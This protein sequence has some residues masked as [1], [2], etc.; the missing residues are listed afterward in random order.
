MKDLAGHFAWIALVLLS[1][2]CSETHEHPPTPSSS[3]PAPFIA[4]HGFHGIH[5]LTFDSEDQLYVGSVMGQS[6]YRVDRETGASQTVLFPPLGMADDLEFDSDGTLVWTSFI[7]GKVHARKKN[8]SE[9][10]ELASG[11]LGINSLAFKQDGRLFATQVFL[12]DAL[13]E[14]DLEGKAPPR[15]ILED[16]GG[17]NGFDFGPDGFLYGPLWF[18]GQVARVNVDTGELSV[19][20]DGFQI[21]AAVNFDSKGNLWVLDSARGEVIQLD[22]ETGERKRVFALKTCMDNLA[23]D[24]ADR[25]FVT[26]M[27]EN[28]IYELDTETGDVR[29]VKEGQLGVPADLAI[30]GESGGETLYVADTF[31]LRAINLETRQV[32]D[33]SRFV[34]DELE[35]P[36][37]IDVS[38]SFVYTASWFSGTIQKLDR[39]T[40]E[41]LD[42]LHGFTTPYDVLELED[43]SLLV[44]EMMASR[45]SRV[46]GPS[47]N[48]EQVRETIASE[49]NGPTSLVDAGG[50]AVYVTLS[51]EGSIARVD[52]DSREVESIVS[53]LVGPEGMALAPDGRL[54]VAEVG[55]SRILAIDPATGE[56]EVV[57]SNVPIGLRFPEGQP[58]VGL[59]TG[60]AVS[61]AGDVFFSSDLEDAIY[62]VP[63]GST[64]RHH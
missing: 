43:G 29:T 52:L 25:L 30:W 6:V 49:L 22:S 42:T 55:Q 3:L 7:L 16:I 2:G 57:A 11:L 38:E 13:Y 26:V 35:Y 62:S 20:A 17:L 27:A 36:F 18:K 48:S 64:S 33:L 56:Q 50:G 54:V 44:A 8:E 61:P 31:V 1:F 21:P 4:G 51:S 15:K 10:R 40:G 45:L 41:I 39:K 47:S 63:L 32:V 5:G 9:I 28:A 53:G 59:S 58:F 14:I 12:G 34:E 23:F 24:S 60:V 19:V 37:G 46:T